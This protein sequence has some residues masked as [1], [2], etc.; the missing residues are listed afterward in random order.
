[1]FY[2]GLD[3]SLRETAVCIVDAD[4]K[5]MKELKVPSD[6]RAA[7]WKQYCRLHDLVVKMVARSELCRHFMAIPGLGPSQH[8]RS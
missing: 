5:I 2:C 7:L 4:G 6:R 3:L 1:M 8:F